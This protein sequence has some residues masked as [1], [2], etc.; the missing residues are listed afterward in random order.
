MSKIQSPEGEE[1]F[2]FSSVL[3]KDYKMPTNFD[4]ILERHFAP[5]FGN[6]EGH[7]IA[8]PNRRQL[9]RRRDMKK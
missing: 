8:V 5:W 2:V 9:P 6:L 3:D 7:D 1:L 4:F